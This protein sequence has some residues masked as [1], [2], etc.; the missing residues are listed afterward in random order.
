MHTPRINCTP[1]KHQKTETTRGEHPFC[2]N[3]FRLWRS[4][5]LSSSSSAVS[6]DCL[7]LMHRTAQTH[8]EWITERPAVARVSACRICGHWHWLLCGVHPRL[9]YRYHHQQI[10]PTVCVCVRVIHCAA[11]VWR[12]CVCLLHLIRWQMTIKEWKCHR[13]EW[14]MCGGCVVRARFTLA[15]MGDGYYSISLCYAGMIH[16]GCDE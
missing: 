9:P 12:L 14:K 7:P 16:F 13:R 4:S 8:W 5:S 2:V 1:T 10:R 6:T 15:V 3:A 11:T